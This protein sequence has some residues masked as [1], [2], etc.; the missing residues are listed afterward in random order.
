MDRNADLKKLTEECKAGYV[1]FDNAWGKNGTQ[2]ADLLEKIDMAVEMNGGHLTSNI[3]EEAQ[4]KLW[5]RNRG[6][7]RPHPPGTATAPAFGCGM[8]LK[9]TVMLSNKICKVTCCAC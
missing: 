6:S 9:L 3:Y 2:V 8:E 7:E 1:V 5:W 4:R